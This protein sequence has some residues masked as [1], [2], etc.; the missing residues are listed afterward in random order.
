MGTH[1]KISL[2]CMPRSGITSKECKFSTLLDMAKWPSNMVSQ[3]VVYIHNGI[4]HSHKKEHNNAICSNM[5]GTTD[6]HTE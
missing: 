2:Q 3:D 6:S 4:L 1:M 5:D